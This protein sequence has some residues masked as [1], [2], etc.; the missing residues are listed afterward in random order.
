MKTLLIII[1]CIAF[2]LLIE[3]IYNFYVK[4]L[5]ED[6]QDALKKRQSEM[7]CSCGSKDFDIIGM[8]HDKLKFQ[9]KYCKKIR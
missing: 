6:K 3:Y 2:C 5:P 7:R 1:G 8:K 4:S 9:C